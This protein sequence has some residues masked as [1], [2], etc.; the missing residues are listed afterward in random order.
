MQTFVQKC[1]LWNINIYLENIKQAGKCGV[2]GDPLN[3][4][5]HETT[6]RQK[7]KAT[8]IYTSGQIIEIRNKVKDKVWDLIFFQTNF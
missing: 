2:C 5:T 6:A 7:F 1:K 4:R 3:V 8:K